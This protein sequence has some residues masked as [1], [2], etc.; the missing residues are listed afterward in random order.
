MRTLLD[1][2]AVTNSGNK[3]YH[4][5]A[6]HRCPDIVAEYLECGPGTTFDLV[7]LRV[8]V[9]S[10]SVADDCLT[11]IIHYKTPYYI[12]SRPL[13]RFF[14]LGVNLSVNTILGT[15]FLEQLKRV[16]DLRDRTLNLRLIGKTLPLVMKEPAL[17]VR[18]YSS[19]A[20]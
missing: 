19:S 18:E 2:G 3:E 7:K 5:K 17:G 16:L 20:G 8:D 13:L 12:A 6:M 9:D 15:P 1:S 4:Q 11:A 10:S 14:A